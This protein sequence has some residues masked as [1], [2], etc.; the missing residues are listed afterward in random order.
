LAGLKKR[1]LF[2]RFYALG[3]DPQL[4]ASAHTDDCGHNGRI[5][6]SGGDLTDKRLVDLQGI[7]RELPQIAKLE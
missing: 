3:N 6:G 2:L 4:Q 5:V 1:Q 7:D